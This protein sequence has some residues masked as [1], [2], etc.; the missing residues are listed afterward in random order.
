MHPW[1]HTCVKRAKSER[2]K[3][4]NEESA[5]RNVFQRTC[6]DSSLLALSV[7]GLAESLGA[8]K[9]RQQASNEKWVVG[10]WEH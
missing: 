8:N 7:I 3:E 2:G 6:L 1:G 9:E 5:K 10:T 4:K